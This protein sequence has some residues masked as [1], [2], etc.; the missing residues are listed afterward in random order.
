MRT[1]LDIRFLFTTADIQT[2][3]HVKRKIVDTRI[4]A[5]ASGTPACNYCY[6][7][8]SWPTA[9]GTKAGWD[10]QRGSSLAIRLV[11]TAGIVAIC[12]P[13]GFRKAQLLDEARAIVEQMQRGSSRGFGEAEFLHDPQICAKAVIDAAVDD[14]ITIGSLQRCDVAALEDAFRIRAATGSLPRIWLSMDR[15]SEIKL[16]RLIAD[17]H[18][19]IIGPQSLLANGCDL[20]TE[21]ARIPARFRKT[22]IEL[23]QGWP[24]AVPFLTRWAQI[25]D[26]ENIAWDPIEIV[27]ASGLSA[28]IEQEVTPLLTPDELNTLIH[29]SVARICELPPPK[30]EGNARRRALISASQNLAGLIIRSGEKIWMQPAFRAWLNGRFCTLPEAQQ[31]STLKTAATIQAKH[32]HLIEAAHLLQQAGEEE[33]IEDLVRDHGSLLIWVEHGFSTI[34]ELVERA[35]EATVARSETLQLMRCIVLMKSGRIAEAQSL[36]D[37]LDGVVATDPLM[38]RDR[39][40]VRVTLLVY[41]CGL[42]READLEQFRGIVAQNSTEPGWQSLLSTLSCILNAQRARFDAAQASLIDARVHA[43]SAESHYNLMFLSLHEANIFLAK[44]ELKNAR[45]A[46][47]EARKRWRHEFPEDR[48]A[49]TVLCAL[50]AS[51]E[52]ERGQ[53]TSARGSVRRSAYRMS[54]SEAWFDVYAA[55]YEPMARIIVLDHGLGPVFEALE[56]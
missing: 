26:P 28:F 9:P 35:G 5:F 27:D 1:D 50:S 52:Y 40:I 13:P 15:P 46:I 11:Q 10:E 20:R 36:F 29:S 14:V 6:M 55:A 45:M 3:R 30:R 38:S 12:A 43:R 44:G 32:G 49:E 17:G 4:L 8:V 54:E 33:K 56:D 21:T 2:F 25:T 19:E 16:A 31:I 22:I 47:G 41:G 18:A 53:I 34:C 37:R 7:T 24:G 42:Q 51:L 39:E 23:A 48:G